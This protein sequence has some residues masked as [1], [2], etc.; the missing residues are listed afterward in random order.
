VIILKSKWGR[1]GRGFLKIILRNQPARESA[2]HEGVKEFVDFFSALDLFFLY[3][4]HSTKTS[5]G[6]LKKINKMIWSIQ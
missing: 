6:K 1:C 3:K 2:L 4:R 5:A